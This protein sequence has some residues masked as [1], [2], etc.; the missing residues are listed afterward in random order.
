MR[1]VRNS[2]KQPDTIAKTMRKK[3]NKVALNIRDIFFLSN[4]PKTQ[5]QYAKTQHKYTDMRN[6]HS[7]HEQFVLTLR[8]NNRVGIRQQLPYI[9]ATHRQQTTHSS[10]LH[11][12]RQ[13][14]AD[15]YV[16]GGDNGTTQ[17]RRILLLVKTKLIFF[18]KLIYYCVCS[19]KT[20]GMSS[21]LIYSFYCPTI[22]ILLYQFFTNPMILL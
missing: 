2:V 17:Y 12:T 15:G 20:P 3:N 22:S 21:F 16:H 10:T 5:Q 9:S 19:K 7:I 6:T 8:N 14:Y 13:S 11:A 1:I 4:L 18:Q